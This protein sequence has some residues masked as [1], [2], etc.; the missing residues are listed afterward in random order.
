MKALP[1]IRA[2]LISLPIVL[3]AL[4]SPLRAETTA[5]D[6]A[7]P[8]QQV[9]TSQIQAFREHDAP[10][11]FS[12]AGIGFQASFPNAESFFVAVIQSGYTPIME[13]L[14]HKFGEYKLI[15][16]MGVVQQVKFIGS[17]QQLYEA[18]YQLTEESGGWRVQG[19][20]LMAPNGVAV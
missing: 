18:V 8:W 6:T 1:N 9:I 7:A 19:V 20:Y 4:T 10:A 5:T 12:L 15:G 17:D 14:S 16:E 2:W 11:A 13:S 3:L